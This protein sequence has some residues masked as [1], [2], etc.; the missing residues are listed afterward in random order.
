MLLLVENLYFKFVVRNLYPL[1][2]AGPIMVY[3]FREHAFNNNMI[4]RSYK[5]LQIH[6]LQN[7][8]KNLIL[9]F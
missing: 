1:G 2:T 3:Y 8:S 6:L 7:Q 9:L 4:M 5:L